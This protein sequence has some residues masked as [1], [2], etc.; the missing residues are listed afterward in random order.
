M[1]NLALRCCYSFE[2]RRKLFEID[3]RFKFA[4]V[5]AHA[6]TPTNLF[7][8]A[9]YLHDDEWLFG[10]K[11][12]RPPLRYSGDFVERTGGVYWSFAECRTQMDADLLDAA[13]ASHTAPLGSFCDHAGIDFAFGVELHRNREFDN[14]VE[15]PQYGDELLLERRLERRSKVF[16]L[17]GKCF[18][19]FTDRGEYPAR[20]QAPASV[21]LEKE[22]WNPGLALPLGVSGGGIE[23]K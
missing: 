6:G 2:N 22:K 23:Y 13:H 12:A 17:E 16:V 15:T 20:V 10:D 1:K 5:V 9:F 11:A 8:C 4:L 3:S 21:V 18:N 19:Q 7:S 14:R